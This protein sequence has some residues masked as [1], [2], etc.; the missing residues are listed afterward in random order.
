[1]VTNKNMINNAKNTLK[2]KIKF[3]IIVIEEKSVIMQITKIKKQCIPGEPQ[4][5][6][7]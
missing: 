2:K 5:S 3:D 7:N 1:M 6:V 4:K